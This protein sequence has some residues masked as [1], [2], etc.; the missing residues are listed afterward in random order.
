[1]PL[2]AS[3]RAKNFRERVKNGHIPKKQKP[4]GFSSSRKDYE[5]KIA[6]GISE[7]DYVNMYNSQMGCCF[8]CGEKRDKLVV[9][10]NHTTKDVRRLLCPNCNFGLGFFQDNPSLLRRAASYV[11]DM[12]IDGSTSRLLGA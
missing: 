3:Q 9:D 8:L 11:I 12:L 7:Q 5:L 10:H 6:Y 1:M 2:T 4:R